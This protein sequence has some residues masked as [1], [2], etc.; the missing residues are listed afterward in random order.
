M[1]PRHLLLSVLFP[2]ITPAAHAQNW[3]N[4]LDRTDMDW[5]H[6]K[7]GFDQHW[8]GRQHEKG[9]GYKQLMRLD[10][11]LAPRVYPS[12]DLPDLAAYAHAVR[13][14]RSAPSLPRMKSASWTEL[15]PRSWT[16]ISFNPGNGRVN[17][18]V[19]D[20]NDPATIYVGS[21]S[22]G[23]WRSQDDG[24]NWTAMLLDLPPV[25]VSDIA[26][27]PANSSTIY[28]ATGDGDGGDTYALGVLKSTDGGATWNTTGLDWP[29]T[30]TRTTRRLIM[31]PTDPQTLLCA[32][33]SGI[34][35]TTDGGATWT[36]RLA[37]SSY[38]VEYKP[39][40][41]TIVYACTDQFF[42]STDGGASFAPVITGVPPAGDVNRMAIAVS[43][44]D[45]GMVY[46]LCGRED[47]S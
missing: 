9:K 5:Y 33:N 36:Q 40:D 25:G 35:Q 38:D 20:P 34:W 7:A 29:Q 17:C 41:P 19:E 27:D 8:Q 44:A 11:F 1:R 28:I 37:G 31:H 2:C 39:G 10:A 18:V 22:G 24:L 26:I 3:V 42:R 32:T 43:A 14:R 45:P 6:L 23:L 4:D 46:L 13:V 30:L 47:D 15:G 21:P 16:S 12:G